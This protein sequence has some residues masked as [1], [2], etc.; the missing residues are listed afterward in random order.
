ML[1]NKTW[2]ISAKTLTQVYNSLIRSLLEYSSIIYPLFSI[3]NLELLERIQYK[4]LKI[5]NK[6]PKYSSNSDIK[7]GKNYLAIE[8]RLDEL[9]L[10]YIKNSLKNN[11][12]IIVDL[13]SDYKSYSN[14]RILTK[15]TLFCK[16]KELI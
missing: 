12:E 2:G 11:N 16:Y 10:R 15:Q 3:S 8:D 1:S 7:N 4:C 5:I 14:A 13:L 6:K 9:N